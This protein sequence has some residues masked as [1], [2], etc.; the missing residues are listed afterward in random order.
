M[1]D[2]VA[3]PRPP[4]TTRDGVL[5]GA[6]WGRDLSRD[7]RERALSVSLTPPARDTCPPPPLRCQQRPSS[8]NDISSHSEVDPSGGARTLSEKGL[9]DAEPQARAPLLWSER[10]ELL[11]PPHFPTSQLYMQPGRAPGMMWLNATPM[12][13]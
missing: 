7:A 6:L 8:M 12:M 11:P 5:C 9:S 10:E 4:E 13:A 3:A 1:C 2:T